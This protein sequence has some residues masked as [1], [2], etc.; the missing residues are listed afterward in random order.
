MLAVPIVFLCLAIPAGDVTESVNLSHDMA[1]PP[2]GVAPLVDRADPVAGSTDVIFLNYDGAQLTK[3]NSFDDDATQNQSWLCGGN[4][5]AW[6]NNPAKKESINQAFS[7]DWEAYQ[8]QITTA[9]P[10]SGNYTMAMIGPGGSLCGT[11]GAGVAPVDC[12]NGEPDSVVYSYS[13]S[14]SN[15]SANGEATVISQEVAHSYGLEHVNDSGDIMNPNA[16]GNDQYFKDQCTQLAGSIHCGSQHSGHCAGAS[17]NG[18]RELLDILGPSSPDTAPPSVAITYPVDGEAFPSAAGFDIQ[19]QASDDQAVSEIQLW[20]DG[21][22]T[23]DRDH[24]QPWGWTV[25]SIPDGIYEFQVIALDP[26]GNQA[27]SETVTITVNASGGSGGSSDPTSDSGGGSLSTG[28]HD[29]LPPGFGTDDPDQEA[30]CACSLPQPGRGWA[31]LPL[32][33]AMALT[34]RRKT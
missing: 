14:G 7:K 25:N 18:H 16:G 33:L 24:D 34:R 28:G 12:F 32:W 19:V 5:P 11:G 4:F 22:D 21:V 2:P 31:V 30:G 10:G 9:R 17:Q 23:G 26:A 15:F 3:N 6:G 27:A 1:V 29:A 8:V 20:I 13:S